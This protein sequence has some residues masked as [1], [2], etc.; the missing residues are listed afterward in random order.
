MVYAQASANC[1]QPGP[2][3]MNQ[4]QI[5]EDLLAFIARDG[6]DD[7]TFNAMALRVFGYQFEH[8]Q[9]YRRFCQQRGRT[10]RMVKDWRDIPAVP[11]NAYK[12]LTLSCCAPEDAGA[13]FMTSGTT[14]DGLR[15]KCHH[16]DL[17]VYDA[18]MKTHFRDRFMAGQT[19]MRIGIV[20][21]DETMMPNSSLAHYL[22]LAMREFGTPDSHSLIGPDGLDT[23]TL[24]AA[25]DHAEA[26]GEPYA[27]LGATYS[28]V[29]L[30][31]DMRE[32][33]R[34][35]KLPAGSRILDTGGFKGQSRELEMDD[36]YNQL[37]ATFGVPRSDC[38]NMYGMTELSSE[39]YDN[40]NTVVP[41]VK[42]GPH[43]IRSRIINPLT[44]VELPRGDTG[45][46]V[47][48]DLAHFNCV[49]TILTEDAGIAVDDGFMLLG[50]VQGAEA[51]GCSM[52][53]DA[54]LEAARG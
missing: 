20:F 54:F 42:S 28:F 2:A 14:K 1:P 7:D 15:G 37:S 27:L 18:S 43:W 29:H 8:N 51:K 22:A 32:S 26:T 5:I 4:A 30:M 13:V 45:V 11:I 9:P 34:T 24:Y 38:I 33:G 31:D 46:I 6:A 48:C 19:K 50:R 52:A 12:D 53:V 17:R 44:G 16:P 47:H 10:A 3:I 49:S 39:F 40:G 21:P 41:S 23:N 35:A 36:F 25:L